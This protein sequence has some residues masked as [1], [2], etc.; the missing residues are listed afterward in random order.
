MSS[1][2]QCCQLPAFSQSRVK[3]DLGTTL[4]A[5]LFKAIRHGNH[6]TY[7]WH[8]VSPKGTVFMGTVHASKQSKTTERWKTVDVIDHSL[9]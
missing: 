3:H 1:D 8:G 2:G 5:E 6:N 7:F 9:I 4:K